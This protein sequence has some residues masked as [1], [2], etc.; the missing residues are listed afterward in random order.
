MKDYKAALKD[1]DKSNELEANNWQTLSMNARTKHCVGDHA[2]ALVDL[3]C[4]TDI[5]PNMTSDIEA[6]GEGPKETHERML[7]I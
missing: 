2:G 4:N 6:L 1:L 7:L 3:E 5:D